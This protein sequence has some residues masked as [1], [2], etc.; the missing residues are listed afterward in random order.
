[1][2]TMALSRLITSATLISSHPLPKEEEVW[3][4]N[5]EVTKTREQRSSGSSLKVLNFSDDNDNLRDSNGEI[6]SA[7]LNA[8]ALPE[9]FTICAAFMAETWRSMYTG[10]RIFTIL[11][12]DGYTWGR[13]F[14][15]AANRHPPTNTVFKASL[16]PVSFVKATDAVFFP[17][18]WTRACLS[19]GATKVALMVDGQL[20][21]EEEYR[22]EEDVSRPA[23]FSLQL[24]IFLAPSGYMEE[25]AGM[26]ANLNVF[27]SSLNLERALRLTMPGDLECG[28][29]G[30][31][32]S[33]EEADWTL[34]SQPG[35]G[36]RS[37]QG[38]GGAL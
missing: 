12:A 15:H 2:L 16:G 4:G 18:Q 24:G 17:L 31:V 29:Q 34:H 28:R 1:M 36:G 14:F 7:T 37:G 22:R 38:L 26:V 10:A 35:K 21:G 19:V 11:R 6:T 8:G 20:L 33:W 9:A 5:K 13:V 25:Y 3:L 27:N 23:N 32:L 30:D